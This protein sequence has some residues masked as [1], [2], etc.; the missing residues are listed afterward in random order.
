M[1]VVTFCKY[2]LGKGTLLK[3]ESQGSEDHTS[4]K[5]RA[6]PVHPGD[7]KTGQTFKEYG[8]DSSWDQAG[9]SKNISAKVCLF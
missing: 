5:Q 7:A 1:K 8:L 6:A 4:H 9:L 3:A 2:Q